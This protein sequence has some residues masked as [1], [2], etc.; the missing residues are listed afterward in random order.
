MGRVEK[1]ILFLKG[2]MMKEKY[3]IAHF[4]N[5]GIPKEVVKNTLEDLYFY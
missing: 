5:K 2:G 1:E 4:T 3:I